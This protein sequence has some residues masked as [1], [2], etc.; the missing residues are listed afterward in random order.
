[1][2]IDEWVSTTTGYS[3]IEE[4][5]NE[6]TVTGQQAVVKK[7]TNL[8]FRTDATK[9]T[10]WPHLIDPIFAFLWP[11]NIRDEFNKR[12]GDRF[13]DHTT[14]HV[15]PSFIDTLKGVQDDWWTL[16]STYFDNIVAIK[17]GNTFELYHMDAVI[18]VEVLKLKYIVTEDGSARTGFPEQAFLMLTQR[19]VKLGYKV[20]KAEPVVR[21]TGKKSKKVPAP[22]SQS[23]PLSEQMLQ[24][25]NL[26]RKKDERASTFIRPE[27][28]K[29]IKLPSYDTT[30][31][32]HK[33]CDLAS[34]V[35][36]EQKPWPHLT[37]ALFSFLWPANIRDLDGHRS[38]HIDYDPKTLFV[39]PQ[40]MEMQSPTQQQWWK[41]KSLYFDSLLAFKVGRFYHM[42]HMDAIVVA[43]A[44][45]L[46]YVQENGR[47]CVGF[48]EFSYKPVAGKLVE[49]GLKVARIEQVETNSS[50]EERLNKSKNKKQDNVL[51]RAICR[52]TTPG[53][54][55]LSEYDPEPVSDMSRYLMAIC[56]WV[57]AL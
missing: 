16:K 52:I 5:D 23:T 30:E 11:D 27:L 7:L 31:T 33:T 14:L 44:I 20:L 10:T 32:C 51:K 2:N 17:V 25:K 42:Y 48:P 8:N 41:F 54:L 36:S 47:T 21:Q 37:D 55:T 50:K 56:E 28:R 29:W 22:C 49:L 19:L 46:K 3:G 45:K 43:D 40:F 39:P 18:G 34:K 9:K 12:P 13:Y 1:M 53:T 4:M 35:T 15:P 6:A 26:S 57:R 38:S 24:D